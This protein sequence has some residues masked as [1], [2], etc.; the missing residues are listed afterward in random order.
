MRRF[1]AV[2][3]LHF[4]VWLIYLA[5]SDSVAPARAEAKIASCDQSA[6][7]QAIAE[8]TFWELLLQIKHQVGYLP[9][10]WQAETLRVAENALRSKLA[11]YY[12]E[13]I[14]GVV[15]Q[16]N[17]GPHNT[18]LLLYG[19][20]NDCVW[21]IGKDGVVAEGNAGSINDIALASLWDGLNVVARSTRA[22]RVAGGSAEPTVSSSA[23][24]SDAAARDKALAELSAKVLPPAIKN[25]LQSL[26]TNSRLLILR[27]G[28]ISKIPFSALP[29]G[30]VPLIEKAAI[31]VVPSI[32][33]LGLNAFPLLDIPHA[34]GKFRN[35]FTG[36]ILLQHE[37]EHPSFHPDSFVSNRQ[38]RIDGLQQYGAI[39]KDQLLL[40]GDPDLSWDRDH[41]YDPLPSAA[42]EM[43]FA[44][45]LFGVSKP[46]VRDEA[47][48][49][50]VHEALTKR[51]KDLR[52]IYFAT[53]GVADTVNPA[54]GGYLALA[55]KHLTGAKL[56][57][58]SLT[59]SP[60]VVMSACETG[61][62]KVFEGGVF[63]LAEAWYQSGAAQIV[64][65]LWAVDDKG[66]E[67]LMRRFLTQLKEQVFNYG[68]GFGAEF[69]LATAAR[70]LKK[71][72]SDPA[73]WA[74][75]VVYGRP[76][77]D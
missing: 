56:R 5:S 77:P 1:R 62:G 2:S 18:V 10:D 51:A 29:I 66:T 32:F 60:V 23:A 26:Q 58:A 69:A 33:D 75:F 54:D 40:V 43:T 7:T 76:S 17:Q 71:Q 25:A 35:K 36:Q 41:I 70:D 68:K 72:N 24:V 28:Q 50:N 59:L 20:K 34:D 39:K 45:Q 67:Q 37:L 11:E 65:S 64:M 48:Y 30:D 61:L 47:N 63:G 27:S 38:L 19:Y 52:L 4:M 57:K 53:H 16:Y 49:A 22:V 74:A 15:R 46:L 9:P 12:K 6:M 55:Q 44:A 21:L 31:V 3:L 14:A 42:A 13:G 8:N 73:V